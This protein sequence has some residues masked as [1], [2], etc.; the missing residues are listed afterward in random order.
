MKMQLI[1][2]GVAGDAGIDG[3]SDDEAWSFMEWC[4]GT[5]RDSCNGAHAGPL[6]T[7]GSSVVVGSFDG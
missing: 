5:G 2:V 3:V 7:D 1:L 6:S 4:V